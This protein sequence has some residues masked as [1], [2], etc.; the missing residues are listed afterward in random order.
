MSDQEQS[1]SGGSSVDEG[2]DSGEESA[3]NPPAKPVKQ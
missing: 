3:N 1:E 2:V